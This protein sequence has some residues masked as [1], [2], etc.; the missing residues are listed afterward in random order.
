MVTSACGVRDAGVGCICA[1]AYRL[2]HKV[3]VALQLSW[4]LQRPASCRNNPCCLIRHV[5]LL[6]IGC[7]TGV[8]CASV[9]RVCAVLLKGKLSAVSTQPGR[10]T[11]TA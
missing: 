4:F 8:G 7:K 2:Q 3:L 11:E 6:L 1:H 5:D 9:L 10:G